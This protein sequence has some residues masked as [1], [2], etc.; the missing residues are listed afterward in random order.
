MENQFWHSS[1]KMGWSLIALSA[2]IGLLSLTAPSQAAVANQY[3]ALNNTASCSPLAQRIE[4]ETAVLSGNFEIGSAASASGE[5]F[6]H[7]PDNTTN[8]QSG[9]S[10][11]YA[12]FCVDILASGTY[13]INSNIKA[14]E[15]DD[16]SFYVAIDDVPTSGYLWDTTLTSVF[17]NDYV[18]ER[19]GSDPVTW[20][21]TPGQ[22]VIR[23]YLREDGTQL[24]WI[25]VEKIGD[26]PPL[27]INPG[28]QTNDEN[29]TVSLQIDALDPENGTLT[30]SATGLPDNLTISN[31]T[32]EIS[33]ILSHDSSGNYD[34]TVTVSDGS[35]SPT[36]EFDWTVNNVNQLPTLTNPGDQSDVE[37]ETIS[38]Q[39][40]ADDA[41]G[42]TLTY[43]ATNLPNNLSMNPSSGLITG[44]LTLGS[45]GTYAVTVTVDDGIDEVDATL[46]WTVFAR[47]EASIDVEFLTNGSNADSVTGPGLVVGTAVNWEYNI[48]NTGNF[49][50]INVVV[51]DDQLGQICTLAT[52]DIDEA[53]TCSDSGTAVSGQYSATASVTGE[54]VDAQGDPARHP[55]NSLVDDPTDSD[56]SHYVGYEEVISSVDLELTTNGSDADSAP[57]IGANIGDPISWV[58]TVTND[59]EIDLG[60]ITVTDGEQGEI[61]TIPDLEPNESASCSIS[62]T[63]VEGQYSTTATATGIPIDENG[64]P[65][66]YP[67][68]LLIPTATDSD[69]THYL[70]FEAGVASIDVE[71]STN[72][73]DADDPTGPTINF[74][75]P[76]EW[77]Y[78]VTNDG[79]FDLKRVEIVDSVLGDVCIINDLAMNETQTCTVNDTAG[80]GQYAAEA[81][82]VG[83]PVDEAGNSATNPDGSEVPDATDSD[84]SHYFGFVPLLPDIDIEFLTNDFD[85]DDPTGPIISDEASVS[86]RYV[87]ENT[88]NLDLKDVTVTD[89]TLGVVCTILLLE[90][91]D[92]TECTASGTAVTG[93]YSS[94][95]SVTGTPVDDLGNPVPDITAPTDSDDSHYLGVDDVTPAI[96]LEKSVYLGHSD[97]TGCVASQELVLGESGTAVTFCFEITNFG[98]TYINSLSLDDPALNATISDLELLNLDSY[99]LAPGDS[100]TLY[101]ETT[102]AGDLLNIATATGVPVNSG[103]TPYV[104]INAP[105]DSDT[106]EIDALQLNICSSGQQERLLLY[107]IGLGNRYDT[108]NPATLTLPAHLEAN[109]L[110]TQLVGRLRPDLSTAVFPNLVTYQSVMETINLA[111][112]AQVNTYAYA[113]ETAV[114]PTT[115]LTVSWQSNQTSYQTARAMIAQTT[116]PTTGRFIN[117]SNDTISFVY[118]RLGQDEANRTLTFAP[119][120]AVTTIYAQVAVV[121]NH[122]DSSVLIVNAQAGN[123][124]ETQ[125][126]VNASDGEQ[127]NLVHFA[128]RNV[129][130]G[131]NSVKVTL[132]SP[133]A[134]GDSGVLSQVV[135]NVLCTSD[136]DGDDV[137][138]SD[139][140]GHD[141][142]GDNIANY[143]DPDDDNDGVPTIDE[144]PNGNN[145]PLDD[146][147]DLDGIPNYLDDDDDGDGV[148][149]AVELHHLSHPSQIGDFD[150]DG[151][152]NYLDEDDDND[153]IPTGS[154]AGLLN[155]FGPD[156]DGD[157][158]ADSI[159]GPGNKDRDGQPNAEDLDSDNDEIPDAIEGAGDADGDNIPNFLDQDSDGDTITDRTEGNVD[160][161]GDGIPNFLDFDSDGDNVPD[162]EERTKDRD[163]DDIPNYL[164]TDADGDGIPDFDEYVNDDAH[165]LKGC[166]SWG[167]PNCHNNDLDGDGIKNYLDTDSD[168]DGTLDGDEIQ[169]A[170]FTLYLPI[171]VR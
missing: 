132:I 10:T 8:F 68:G 83:E 45:A 165:L 86:W 128:L 50:L 87:V 49:D 126:L 145:N 149:T 112:P 47:P 59:G 34:V 12:E 159:E 75:E 100:T 16:N 40:V 55:D 139:D 11:H 97:G 118:H 6:I 96:Q 26:D 104:G 163:H 147:T 19:G 150:H 111:T 148:E 138:D 52:L 107:G 101:Y 122:A 144:D 169:P 152:P 28:N 161:D 88:G 91:D 18:S 77:V 24:D 153:G 154:E 2:L 43:S 123:V 120:T 44:Q 65:A 130:I 37:N 110:N 71:M 103:G 168:N 32:G 72:G 102:I 124:I 64:D 17:V 39:I 66:E 135:A 70:G 136:S 41:D 141:S 5:Q 92:S 9:P 99:P 67:G 30:Y 82:V 106:A 57:G 84:M 27:I 61:C 62:D 114:T 7:V 158:I 155:G 46:T 73:F 22:R 90:I 171:V 94:T 53:T 36:I 48:T 60:S 15:G 143:L 167:N 109:A 14:P 13:Q 108:T 33:G 63:A 23:L 105:S 133:E 69:S 125:T 74:G 157:G 129:P 142:D 160:T 38:L 79:P 25:E 140:G 117:K 1:P 162:S 76:I 85:A 113:F 131:T 20:S 146:D 21:L 93:Q 80:D 127:L 81:S 31:S 42:E 119:T 164:D 156:T 116:Y 58:Y 151:I 78:T 115:E 95:A 56:N 4:A 54:P 89:S 29:D 35:H 51:T 3:F 121:G 137:N 134:N 166:S 170:A 98:N